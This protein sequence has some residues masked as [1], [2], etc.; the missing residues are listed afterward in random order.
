MINYEMKNLL[1]QTKLNF[2]V[3][4]LDSKNTITDKLKK[5]KKHG[6]LK[7]LNKTRAQEHIIMK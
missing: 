2:D 6:R 1:R 7:K 5:K 3:I 4:E